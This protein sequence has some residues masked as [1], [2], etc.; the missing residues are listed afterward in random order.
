MYG[1]RKKLNNKEIYIEIQ[2]YNTYMRVIGVR[3]SWNASR[4]C[5]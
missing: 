4:I 2:I 1:E 3:E 5:G